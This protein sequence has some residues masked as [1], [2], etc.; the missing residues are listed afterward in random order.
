M[1]TKRQQKFSKLILEE[2]AAIFA[3]EGKTIFG[4]AFITISE[5]KMTPDLGLAKI[6]LSLQFIENKDEV[7]LALNDNSSFFRGVLG[8]RI[9]QSVRIIPNLKFYEDD[10]LDEALKMNQMIDKLDIPSE[11]SDKK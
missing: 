7:V 11:D 8:K 5:V 4:S 6:Y 3:K 9:K 10:T 1:E 2:M